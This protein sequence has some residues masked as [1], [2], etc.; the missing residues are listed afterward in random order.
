MGPGRYLYADKLPKVGFA[1]CVVPEVSTKQQ[2]KIGY[3]AP[4]DISTPI[5]LSEL[6]RTHA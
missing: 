6:V 4:A 3:N 1:C 5:I 2:K